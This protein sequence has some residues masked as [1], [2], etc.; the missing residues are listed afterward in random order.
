MNMAWKEI[1]KNKSRFVI[2]GSI[3]F[4]VSLLT[5]IISGLANGLSQDNAA[6]I[7]DM[8]E[9]TFY[10]DADAD[11]TYNLSKIDIDLADKTIE[12]NKDASALSIQMGFM[13]DSDD[14][15]VSVAFATATNGNVFPEVKNGEVL[16]DESIKDKGIEVGDVLT[17]NQLSKDLTVKG[18]VEQ[19]KFS[20][21]PVAFINKE[22]YQEMYRVEEMQML[23]IPGKE[24]PGSI[25][26]LQAFSNKD[27]L[28]TIPSYSAEQLSLNMIVWFLVVISGMLFGIF[29]YM[30]NVQKIGLY[31][32]LKA[33]GVKTS[34]LFKMMWTQMLLITAIALALSVSISQLFSAVAPDGMPFHLTLATTGQ[35]AIVFLIIGF[36][37]ATL[38]GIQIKKIQPLQ[39]IQQ[40]EM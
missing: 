18:F 29:F 15:Q 19:E 34:T 16:L 36:I 20:H 1:I 31:G 2:L 12:E 6:L 25:N 40:G 17:N 4:L 8:P 11:E 14:K 26:G 22:N 24:D 32:I 30:M 3:V 37:G 33:I 21:S 28:N 23:F 5:L 10:M 9:G 27:F 13:N 39:A 38:S 35:L 7:K